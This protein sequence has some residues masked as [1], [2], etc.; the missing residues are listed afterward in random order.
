MKKF[1]WNDYTFF[2][3]KESVISNKIIKVATK[4]WFDVVIE[5]LPANSHVI[6]LFR[7]VT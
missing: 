2:L 5:K 3:Q 1:N 6:E 7:I 4:K